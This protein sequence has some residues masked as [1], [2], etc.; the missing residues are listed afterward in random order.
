MNYSRAEQAVTVDLAA[1]TATSEGADSLSEIENVIGS[2]FDDALTGDSGDNRFTGGTGDDLI[3]GGGGRDTA[4]FSEA[5]A[6]VIVDL[7]AGTATGQGQ[8]VLRSIESVLG[9]GY[10]DRLTGDDGVNWLTGRSGDDTLIGGAGNDTA[11]FSYARQGVT[12]DLTLGTA[13][14]EGEDVLVGIEDVT[15]SAH[16]DVLLGDD[17]P[18]RLFSSEGADRIIAAGGDDWV[19]GD[20]G[21]DTVSAGAGNDSVESGDGEDIVD[22]GAGA[23]TIQGGGGD[24]RLAGGE[25][26]DEL[27]GGAGDDR[28][29]GGEAADRLFGDAGN[30][31]LAGEA[32]ADDLYGGGGNDSLVGDAGSDS[33]DGGSGDD[34]L[35]GGAGNDTLIGDDGTD[36]VDFS[37][38]ARSV[39]V[40]LE[41]FS[42]YGDGADRLYGIENVIGSAYADQL[43]GNSANNILTG[44]GGADMLVSGQGRDTFVFAEGSGEDI[45][46]DFQV[47]VDVID[48]R[49]FG[50]GD[51][52]MLAAGFEDLGGE[53][54]VRYGDHSVLLLG[55]ATTDLQ[56]TDFLLA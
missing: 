7:A 22:G 41:A 35:V 52:A 38:A 15:G 53:T 19:K 18:N 2:A 51:F 12:V 44:G 4:V 23:D 37:A 33:L 25:A 30:D 8:D 55:I 20:A 17:A 27:W 56:G 13:S 45:I 32:G 36:T 54:L 47:G 1:G 26:A 50:F 29:A 21:N 16:D 40:S 39:S 6:G 9:T 24:D 48:L 14:G 3:D 10:D 5:T 46:G 11:S 42:A 49:A 31:T 28:L 34:L 43:W